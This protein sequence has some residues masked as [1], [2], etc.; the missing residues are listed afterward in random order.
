MRHVPAERCRRQ[1]ASASAILAR[2]PSLHPRRRRHDDK[3]VRPTEHR[4]RQC[5]HT[6]LLARTHISP[7]RLGPP[8]TTEYYRCDACETGYQFAPA[9]GR[10]KPWT[11]EDD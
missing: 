3:A 2:L 11:S 6:L 9:T 8:L 7:P 5:G 1:R 10:W 4:C